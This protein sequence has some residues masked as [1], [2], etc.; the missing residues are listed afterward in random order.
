MAIYSVSEVLEERSERCFVVEFTDGFKIPIAYRIVDDFLGV[1]DPAAITRLA[2]D[3]RGLV[4]DTNELN[5][6][7]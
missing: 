7:E 2:H 6:G 3:L 4:E 1:R 5:K